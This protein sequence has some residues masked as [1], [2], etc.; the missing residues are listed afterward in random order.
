M[1]YLLLAA[2]VLIQALPAFSQP[3][4]DVRLKAISLVELSGARKQIEASL[5]GLIEQGQAAMRKQCPDCNPAFFLEWG[6]R[7]KTRLKVEDFVNVAVRAYESHF[8]SDELTELLSAAGAKNAGRQPTLSPALQKK[9]SETLPALLGEIN[10]GCTEIGAQIGGQVG[11]EI[12]NEHP[13]YFPKKKGT[14]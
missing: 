11:A 5:P 1:K 7:M 3:S 13:E 8:N 12:E 4:D 6:N 14:E 9:L 10:G 2:F